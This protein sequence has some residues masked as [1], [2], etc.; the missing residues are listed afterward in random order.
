MRM[1]KEQLLIAARTAAKYLPAASADIMN[2]LANRLD[3]NG[4]VWSVVYRD[5]DEIDPQIDG[6]DISAWEPETPDGEGWF[7]GSIHDSEDG[8]VCIWLRAVD[9]RGAQK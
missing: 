2:E 7:V 9:S 1:T 8:A 6:Y 4:L 5:E 3:V